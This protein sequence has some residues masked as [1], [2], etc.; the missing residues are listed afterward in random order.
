[1][2]PMMYNKYDVVFNPNRTV[3]VLFG[4]KINP[5]GFDIYLGGEK[6]R[7]IESFK[8]LGNIVTSDL[9]DDFDIH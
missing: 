8:H 3:C 2:C 5:N 9:W 6:L 1:M 7:W 4:C